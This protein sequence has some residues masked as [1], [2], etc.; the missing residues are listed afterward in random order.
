MTRFMSELEELQKVY[1]RL[2]LLDT[3]MLLEAFQQANDRTIPE[4]VFLLQQ[5]HH[6][7]KK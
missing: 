1:Q 5:L 4:I 7:R 6:E 3:A 2:E